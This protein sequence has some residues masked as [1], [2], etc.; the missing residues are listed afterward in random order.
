MQNFCDTNTK[1]RIDSENQDTIDSPDVSLSKSRLIS[2]QE[3]DPEL[4]LPPVKL[5][6]VPVSY[7]VRNGVLMR[8]WRPPNVPASEEWSVVHQIVVPK[9]YQSEILKLAYE[10]SMGGHLGCNKTYSRITKHFYWP[11]V[12]CCVTEFCMT[13]HVCQM[14][15]KPNQKIPVAP[16]KPIPAFEEPFSKVIIDCVGPLPKTKSRIQYLLTI[17]CASTRFPE[18]RPLTNITAPK[19]SN[20]LVNFFT[21]V[22]LPEELQSDQGSNFMSGLYQQVNQT[23]QIT[24]NYKVHVKGS[25]PL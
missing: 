7:Y 25:I 9:V 17:M 14:V 21:L 6:K 3:N 5:V 15:G 13:C 20:A 10:S 2:E 23:D 16:L 18:A 4:V 12:R 11:Q 22:G 8:K 19:I 24:R 1:A